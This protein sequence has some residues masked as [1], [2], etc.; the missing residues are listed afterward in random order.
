M[1]HHEANEGMGPTKREI[2]EHKD[3][4]KRFGAQADAEGWGIFNFCEIQRD[5]EAG[6]FASD[7][8]AIAFVRKRAKKGS[9]CHSIALRICDLD[10]TKRV[11]A[12][13]QQEPACA[14]T[15]DQCTGRGT[16]LGATRAGGKQWA[17]YRCAA[18]GCNWSLARLFN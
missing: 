18:C 6:T 12:W 13:A 2:A 3:W 8:D 16:Y 4:C 15:K 7:D 1:N 5:D 17:E 14:S 9:E 11:P 10:R